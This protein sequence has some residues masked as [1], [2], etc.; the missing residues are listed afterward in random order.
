MVRLERNSQ[1]AV[2][3]YLKGDRVSRLPR[4]DFNAIERNHKELAELL[5]G[6]LNVE[7]WD[8]SPREKITNVLLLRALI[9]W[10]VFK[11]VLKDPFP[12]LGTE[13]G[14][15]WDELKDMLNE[16]GE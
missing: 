7:N 5:R 2:D 11:W 3:A 12:V 6:A 15:V 14:P 13:C 1:K 16:R 4:P 8:I 10:A 9:G